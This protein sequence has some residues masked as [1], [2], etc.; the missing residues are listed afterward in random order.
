V[1]VWVG[2]DVGGK[3]KGFD[4][5]VI[6]DRRVLALQSHRTCEQVVGIV[7]ANHPAVVAI[8]SPR[9]CAPEGQIA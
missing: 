1:A 2:V 6:D 7:V 3:R 8:D 5:A 9:S 4:V